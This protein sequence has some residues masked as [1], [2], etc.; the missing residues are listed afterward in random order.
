[1]IRRLPWEGFAALILLCAAC[2]PGTQEAAPTACAGK[3]DGLGFVPFDPLG[4]YEGTISAGDPESIVGS[5]VTA[6]VTDHND[7]DSRFPKV[8]VTFR[9]VPNSDGDRVIVVGYDNEKGDFK[10]RITELCDDPGCLQIDSLFVR[11]Y[12]LDS[13][14]GPQTKIYY[15][16]VGLWH[17]GEEP[18]AR[19]VERATLIKRPTPA[20]PQV[21]QFPAD[22]PLPQRI[23]A[24]INKIVYEDCD[25]DGLSY[26]A[27]SFSEEREDG[28]LN[29]GVGLKG[30]DGNDWYSVTVYEDDDHE[31]GVVEYD[32]PSP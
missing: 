13:S 12:Q 14:S 5:S 3:C 4:Q 16:F 17:E 25:T 23:Q 10:G 24:F 1:M 22:A 7:G 31:L 15:R 19:V 27:T 30:T 2:G 11:L 32:C 9:Q 6:V 18:A 20:I 26:K 8:K 21:V 29:Y 28:V